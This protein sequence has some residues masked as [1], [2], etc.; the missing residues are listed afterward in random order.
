MKKTNGQLINIAAL[1]GRL[2]KIFPHFGMAIAATLLLASPQAAKAQVH[3]K[4]QQLLIRVVGPSA[5][6][7]QLQAQARCDDFAGSGETCLFLQT[8]LRTYTSEGPASARAE[9]LC[10]CVDEELADI[11]FPID[12]LRDCKFRNH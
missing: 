11:K 9:G 1:M 2:E 12:V 8:G 3:P 5:Q 10:C 4:F 7:V 6:A